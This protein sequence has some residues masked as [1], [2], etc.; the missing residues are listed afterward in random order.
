[1]IRSGALPDGSAEG[2]NSTDA[3]SGQSPGS[4]LVP[5]QTAFLSRTPSHNACIAPVM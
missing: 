3:F 4:H 1:M 2:P 5:T